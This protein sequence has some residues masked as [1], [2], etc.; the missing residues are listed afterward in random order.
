MK[1]RV[2]SAAGINTVE[3]VS[4]GSGYFKLSQRPSPFPFLLSGGIDSVDEISFS[5]ERRLR[6]HSLSSGMVESKNIVLIAAPTFAESRSYAAFR[7]RVNTGQ[8]CCSGICYNVSI[9]RRR[10]VVSPCPTKPSTN[11]GEKPHLTRSCINTRGDLP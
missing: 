10:S 4:Q 6:R 2:L 3:A 8:G 1:K 11:P 7:R 9:G 5:T